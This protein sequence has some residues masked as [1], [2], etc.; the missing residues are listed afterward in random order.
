MNGKIWLGRDNTIEF[1]LLLEGTPIT[2]HTT[3]TRVQIDL[4]EG[5]YVIDSNTN[6]SWFDLTNTD[7]IILDFGAVTGI[8]AGNY[9]VEIVVYS[10]DYPNGLIWDET[11]KIT[12]E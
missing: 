8:P 12:F 10:A 3:I 7:R 4:N 9:S 11:S 5:T 2:D 6:P 1:K